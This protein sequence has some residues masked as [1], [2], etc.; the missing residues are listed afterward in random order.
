TSLSPDHL[1]WHADS[2]DQ[3]YR[4]KLSICRLPG[5]RV[6][7]VDGTSDELRARRELLGPEV[8]WVAPP[9]DADR[10]WSRA[11]GLRGEHNL[12]NAELARGVLVEL[13]VDAAHDDARLAALS[14][15]FTPLPSRLTT[16]GVV[17]GVEFVDDSLSTNVLP[18]CA[19]VRSFPQRPLVLVVGGF[20]RGI[21]YAPLAAVL[22]ERGPRTFV[23]G[24]PD[25]GSR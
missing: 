7:V 11:L 12:R 17:G 22:A 14:E 3:Y 5:A 18:T 2:V 13:G 24:I 20:D 16:V 4:D 9:A 23:V 21:D 19:A 15:G 8:R 25:N 6:T 1:N 10:A